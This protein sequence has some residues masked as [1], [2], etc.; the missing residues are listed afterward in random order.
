MGSDVYL[1]FDAMSEEEKK[2]QCTGFSI[3]AGNVG[4]LRASIGMYEENQV[5][6]LVF[7]EKYWNNRTDNG[8]KY[9]FI[10]NIRRLPD[11]LHAYLDGEKIK[12]DSESFKQQ[13]EFGNA[14][15]SMV[16]SLFAKEGDEID[17]E[18]LTKQKSE[19]EMWANS[20]VQFFLL[21]CKLQNEG[22]NPKVEISW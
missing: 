10:G 1:N 18:S 22:K 20:V 13:Q 7:P 5:L 6:R 15:T 14:V 9:D 21:G 16:R 11:I 12:I 17:A 19:K 8:L 2:K 4:Y 3:D